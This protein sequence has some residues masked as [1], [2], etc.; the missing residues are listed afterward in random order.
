MNTSKN[1]A[2]IGAICITVVYEVI[3]FTTVIKGAYYSQPL[4]LFFVYLFSLAGGVPI[5][6]ILII[7][8]RPSQ[9]KEV[10]GD[11]K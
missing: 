1:I 10:G 5:A 7:F 6:I 2:L 4:S 11:T 8:A 9:P 3:L